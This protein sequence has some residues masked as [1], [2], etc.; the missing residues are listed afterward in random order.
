MIIRT[1][2]RAVGSISPPPV[3]VNKDYTPPAKPVKP[4]RVDL[5]G[6]M[7]AVYQDLEQ[8]TDEWHEVRRGVLTASSVGKLLTATGKLSQGD[9]AKSLMRSL[10]AERLTGRS[11]HFHISADME[12]G[13]FDEPLAR[14]LYSKTYAPVSEVG[15]MIR[16]F[17]NLRLGYSPDGLVGEDGLIEVKS[18]RQSIQL[19]TVLEDEVP[20]DNM[21]QLQAGLLVSGR[22]WIDY[23]SYSG[24]M[25]MYKI[26]VTPIPAWQATILEA[27]T[28]FEQ[29]ATEWVDDYLRKT[30]GLPDTEYVDWFGEME[31]QL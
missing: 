9:T 15:F 21:A 13:N 4:A 1:G 17:G 14:D 3:V 7:L 24:G 31:M 18:R 2:A 19:K 12:R 27:L 6:S 16:T 22:S 10:V 11:E 23:L 29:Q 8:G 28:V 26:R 25:P 30:E 5:T 20:A